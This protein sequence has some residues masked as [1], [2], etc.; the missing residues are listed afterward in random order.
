MMA[1]RQG[2]TQD[3]SSIARTEWSAFSSWLMTPWV[4]S[5]A[6]TSHPATRLQQQALHACL[7]PCLPTIIAS[8]KEQ[9]ISTVRA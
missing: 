2:L 4:S 1:S 9:L 8:M 3:C 6:L 5:C 7:C